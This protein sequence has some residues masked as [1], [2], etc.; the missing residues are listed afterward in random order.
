MS[1]LL[2][3]LT[4]KSTVCALAVTS[5]SAIAVEV[6][7]DLGF[8]AVV[9]DARHGPTSPY[10]HELGALVRGARASGTAAFA[11]LPESSPGAVNR[12]LNDAVHGIIV[13]SVTDRAEAEAVVEAGRYPPLGKRGAAPVVRAAGY[14][15]RDWDEYREESN[16]Q[17]AVLCSLESPDALGHAESILAVAG[18]DG[19]V[20][21][22]ATVRM[23]VGAS[24][25]GPDDLPAARAVAVAAR[26]RGAISGVVVQS[27]D[28]AMAWARVGSNFVVVESDAS[29]ALQAMVAARSS[30]VEA[31]TR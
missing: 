1:A 18:I 20:I 9:L 2:R 3:L 16:S 12:A 15:V 13:P 29:L 23:A 8:A 25:V 24:G 28:D 21:D 7:G 22:A 26:E 30:M 11:R 5:G 19:V 4:G 10:S 17:R 27:S 31:A 14:G 6:A